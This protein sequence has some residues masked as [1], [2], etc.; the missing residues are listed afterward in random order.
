MRATGGIRK[1]RVALKARIATP[2]PALAEPHVTF[3][4][5]GPALPSAT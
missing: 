3:G 2:S 5:L 1:L 4:S